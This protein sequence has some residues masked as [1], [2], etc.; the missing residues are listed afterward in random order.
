MGIEREREQPYSLDIPPY[1]STIDDELEETTYYP[2]P[3][4][5]TMFS[6]QVRTPDA[7]SGEKLGSVNSV[8]GIHALLMA[9]VYQETPSLLMLNRQKFLIIYDQDDKVN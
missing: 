5:P 9:H 4:F 6:K 8:E 7:I 2:D 1:G 3:A